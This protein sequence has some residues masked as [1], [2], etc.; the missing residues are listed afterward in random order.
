[1]S[2]RSTIENKLIQVLE[3]IDQYYLVRL[4]DLK[5]VLS[6]EDCVG[7]IHKIAIDSKFVTNPQEE[8]L[9]SLI[10][11]FKIENNLN[12]KKAIELISQIKKLESYMVDLINGK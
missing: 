11:K 2:T 12:D 7:K 4:I 1:M 10:E 5:E 3:N 9:R 6:S 8:T